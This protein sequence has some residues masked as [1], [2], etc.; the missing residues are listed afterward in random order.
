MPT[1]RA[2][3]LS[4]GQDNGQPRWELA[5]HLGVSV[6]EL[7]AFEK[8]V[9]RAL[10]LSPQS[11]SDAGTLEG[12]LPHQGPG[13]AEVLLNRERDS[14]LL[15]CVA[16]LP[17]GLRTVARGYFFDE[18]SIADLAAELGVT[19]SRIPQMRAEALTL[20]KDGMTAMLAPD[21]IGHEVRLPRTLQLKAHDPT[22]GGSR[23]GRRTVELSAAWRP[24]CRRWPCTATAPP[25][26]RRG[27]SGRTPR[28]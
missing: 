19:E 26:S 9:H 28:T 14:Y 3:G 17:E 8:D 27:S 25:I 20:L 21:Q 6:D 12:M 1:G 23:I 18:P 7:A 15:D 10:V 2:T 13:P 11:F 4:G 16:A 24:L 5:G 22:C